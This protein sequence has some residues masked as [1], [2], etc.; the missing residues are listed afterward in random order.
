MGLFAKLESKI[1][2]PPFKDH[3]ALGDSI[4]VEVNVDLKIE[5]IVY[6]VNE[7][8]VSFDE[9]DSW[10]DRS[11]DPT[12]RSQS[13]QDVSLKSQG[14]RSRRK[15]SKRKRLNDESDSGD[16]S[17]NDPVLQNHSDRRKE[18]K[19]QVSVSSQSSAH[20]CKQCDKGFATEVM[21]WA[22]IM[23]HH[24]K[25]EIQCPHCPDKFEG[26]FQWNG[27]IKKLHRY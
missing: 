2:H 12:L 6:E 3:I 21:L 19:S 23:T 15:A 14:G 9:S 18:S 7:P 16:P 22:H 11:F 26:L 27:H 13:G 5:E 10:D 17:W 20:A 25:S 24:D 4:K 1:E 8:D